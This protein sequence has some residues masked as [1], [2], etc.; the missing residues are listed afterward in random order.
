MALRSLFDT[1]QAGQ[2][3]L[4]GCPDCRGVLAV[5]EL[6][7]SGYL[8]F[9]CQVGHTFSEDSLLERKEVELEESLWIAAET[10]E[11]L[12]R[13]IRVH[14][15]R[16]HANGIDDEAAML[17]RKADGAAACAEELRRLLGAG[18]APEVASK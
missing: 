4:L 10:C 17:K 8:S 3:T 9:S 2:L 18:L 7:D 12:K 11:E 1:P 6:G 13:L 16:A 5:K 15:E 14:A